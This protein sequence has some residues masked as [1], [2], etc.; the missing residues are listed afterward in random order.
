MS[1]KIVHLFASKAISFCVAMFAFEVASFWWFFYFE[2][3]RLVRKAS[4]GACVGPVVGER[5]LLYELVASEVLP[6]SPAA[7]LQVSPMTVQRAQKKAIAALRLQLV[8]GG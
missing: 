5:S 7:Q 8:G 3:Q 2:L 6:A 1:C 4:I